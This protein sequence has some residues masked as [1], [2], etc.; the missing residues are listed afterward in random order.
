MDLI[1]APLSDVE[2]HTLLLAHCI[3]A[4]SAKGRGF[5]APGVMHE[6]DYEIVL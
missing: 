4:V 3:E 6:G 1:I 2:M 5:A